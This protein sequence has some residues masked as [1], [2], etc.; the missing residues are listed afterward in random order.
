MK[1][2]DACKIQA[3]F[4][5]TLRYTFLVTKRHSHFSENTRD[6]PKSILEEVMLGEDQGAVLLQKFLRDLQKQNV[7]FVS[8]IRAGDIVDT[9]ELQFFYYLQEVLH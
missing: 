8:G 3:V 1:G 4:G 6:S 5:L 2:R 9:L 7:E